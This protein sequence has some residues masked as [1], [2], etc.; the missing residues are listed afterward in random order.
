MVNAAT[1]LTEVVPLERDI[2]FYD[3]VGMKAGLSMGYVLA[4]T[5]SPPLPSPPLFYAT[6]MWRDAYFR[7]QYPDRCCT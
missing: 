4:N 5:P 3:L 7:A 2:T 6:K 1:G